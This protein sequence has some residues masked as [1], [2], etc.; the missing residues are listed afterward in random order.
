MGVVV[1][2]LRRRRVR[3]VR[4][5]AELRGNRSDEWEKASRL[6][7]RLRL[8]WLRWGVAERVSF[9]YGGGGSTA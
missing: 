3:N 6:P 2:R 7:L 9:G 8:R 5:G 4:A 1:A